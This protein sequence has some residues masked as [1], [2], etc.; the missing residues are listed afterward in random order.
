AGITRWFLSRRAIT[1]RIEGSSSTTRIFRSRDIRDL[2]PA[3]AQLQ[4]GFRQRR[5]RRRAGRGLRRREQFHLDRDGRPRP[6]F[7]LDHE[8]A[9][10]LPGERAAKREAEAVASLFGREERFE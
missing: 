7:A 6:R 9:A 4:R 10:V 3:R 2:Q 8:A 5:L 1:R